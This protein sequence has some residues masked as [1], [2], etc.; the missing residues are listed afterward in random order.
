MTHFEW[1]ELLPFFDS[2]NLHI[3]N[4]LLVCLFL[5][6][7]TIC[8]RWALRRSKDPLVPSRHFSVKAFYVSLPISILSFCCFLF[9][10]YAIFC[11][12]V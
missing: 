5:S 9:H 4:M 1:L 8:A 2:K 6:V 11:C 7:L 3:A 10:V 12:V